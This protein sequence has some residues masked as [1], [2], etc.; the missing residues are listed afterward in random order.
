[1]SVLLPYFRVKS[2]KLANFFVI[3]EISRNI[4]EREDEELTFRKQSHKR[5]KL[6]SKNE[7]KSGDI[8]PIKTEPISSSIL[9]KEE[10]I[11]PKLEIQ[12]SSLNLISKDLSCIENDTNSSDSNDDISSVNTIFPYM[13]ILTFTNY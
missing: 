12:D 10:D 9:I 5:A 3:F 13:F 7:K 11:K 1:M 4:S 2:K 8:F 6:L